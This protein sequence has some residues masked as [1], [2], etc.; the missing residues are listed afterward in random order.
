[1]QN[2]SLVS[3]KIFSLSSIFSLIIMCSSMNLFVFI[4]FGVNLAF[5][6]LEV[7]F[8]HKFGKFSA[9]VSSDIV[10][11]PFTLFSHSGSSVIQT[12]LTCYCP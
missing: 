1:M 8:F 12:C 3:F 11:V 6:N 4:L 5:F 7:L 10:L 9:T 2:F